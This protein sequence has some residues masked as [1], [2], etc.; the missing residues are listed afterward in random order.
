MVGA[1]LTGAGSAGSIPAGRTISKYTTSSHLV[2][3]RFCAMGLILG[4]V[5]C[6]MENLLQ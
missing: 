1:E 4:L 2:R 6:K 3:G 5:L